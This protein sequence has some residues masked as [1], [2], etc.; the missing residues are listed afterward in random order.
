MNEEIYKARIWMDRTRTPDPSFIRQGDA[1]DGLY[2]DGLS[3]WKVLAIDGRVATLRAITKSS[4]NKKVKA[5]CA[6]IQM[7]CRSIY[8]LH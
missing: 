4:V 6:A 1:I 3:K 2:I 7:N 5:H 8:K